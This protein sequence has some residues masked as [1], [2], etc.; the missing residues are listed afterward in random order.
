MEEAQTAFEPGEA[1]EA[2]ESFELL[3]A[4]AQTH[5][6]DFLAWVRPAQAIPARSDGGS[7]KAGGIRHR[8]RA[9]H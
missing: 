1:L 3:G 8:E 6:A 4:R 9:L 2:L 7:R 5:V